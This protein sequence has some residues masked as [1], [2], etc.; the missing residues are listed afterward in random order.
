MKS[1]CNPCNC[2]TESHQQYFERVGLPLEGIQHFR[3]CAFHRQWMFDK[4]MESYCMVRL[5]ANQLDLYDTDVKS[6]VSEW[7]DTAD[8]WLNA[9][10][11]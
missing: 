11:S 4:Y 6:E 1:R 7:R 9:Q 3:S 5:G 8:W 10:F 2:Y